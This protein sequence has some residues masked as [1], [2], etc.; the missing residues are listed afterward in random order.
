MDSFTKL[1][2]ENLLLKT[3]MEILIKNNLLY[4]SKK[5]TLTIQNEILN[6]ESKNTILLLNNEIEIL[7]SNVKEYEEKVKLLEKQ[8]K[9]K[10]ENEHKI[11]QKIKKENEINKNEIISKLRI[12]I[13]DKMGLE[14]DYVLSV[15]SSD[16]IENIIK[17]IKPK[18]LYNYRLIF[19]GMFLYGTLLENSICDGSIIYMDR[20]PYIY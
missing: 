19:N 20:C 1:K 8:L 7:E 16:S 4:K 11:K 10:E 13:K 6:E 5:S 15:N 9:N 2:Q 14:G 18:A 12:V 17:Q 3:E